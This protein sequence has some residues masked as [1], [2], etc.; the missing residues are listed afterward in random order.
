MGSFFRRPIEAVLARFVD[1]WQYTQ[2]LHLRHLSLIRDT[3]L[4]GTISYFVQYSFENFEKLVKDGKASWEAVQTPVKKKAGHPPPIEAQP[5]LDE[6]GFVVSEEYTKLVKQGNATL[7]ECL[8]AAKPSN[9]VVTSHD[10]VAVQ[11]RDG[12]YGE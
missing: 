9:Y 8:E 10:P 11:L 2:P 5:K 3:A 7:R 6:H 1:S 4:R 12:T